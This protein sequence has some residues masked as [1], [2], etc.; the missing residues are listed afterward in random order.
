MHSSSLK[1]HLDASSSTHFHNSVLICLI[2]IDYVVECGSYACSVI[3]HLR[4]ITAPPPPPPPPFLFQPIY[5]QFFVFFKTVLNTTITSAYVLQLV[6][7]ASFIHNIQVGWSGKISFYLYP[8][9]YARCDCHGFFCFSTIDISEMIQTRRRWR[10]HRDHD[11]ILNPN[12]GSLQDI[13]C[14]GKPRT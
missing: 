12:I 1:L 2:W 11:C 9:K 13:S 4:F 10:N 8:D 6:V 14:G 5:F 7:F 3:F